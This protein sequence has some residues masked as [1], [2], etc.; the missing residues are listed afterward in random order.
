MFLDPSYIIAGLVDKQQT[1]YFLIFF[2]SD[3]WSHD[4]S[5][6]D[7][8]AFATAFAWDPSLRK[9]LLMHSFVSN[10]ILVCAEIITK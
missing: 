8:N 7:Q 5:R 10:I 3:F 1:F 4:S 2:L 9:L 6:A